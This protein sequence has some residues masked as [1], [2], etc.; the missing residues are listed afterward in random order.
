MI[1]KAA[2]IPI[3]PVRRLSSQFAFVDMQIC[4]TCFFIQTKR[5]FHDD[6]VMR[7]YS[8]YRSP[9]YNQERIRYEPS[10][11]SIAAKVGQ[12]A[13]ELRSRI[14]ALA[15]FLGRNL[16]SSEPQTILDYGGSDG[17][18]I[19]EI[20]GRKFVF[21][22]SDIEPIAGVTRINSEAD[23]GR[24]SIVLLA[25]VI[26]HVPR[27]LDLVRKVAS[28][29]EPGGFL[30]IETPQEIPDTERDALRR[31]TR[32]F[33]VEIHEHINSYCSQAVNHLLEAAGLKVAAIESTAVD[34]GW[35]RAVHIRALGRTSN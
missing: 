2:L 34:V 25:H 10:Y 24:Y 32:R 3:S 31:G 27:P 7:L 33:Q 30:Y 13:V 11:A 12:D 22:V 21:E 5:P 26:E 35:A 16:K 28:R 8:D 1:R 6:D 9:S 23:L 15:A 20:P 14:A 29:V 4:S 17:K 18:F 19:P